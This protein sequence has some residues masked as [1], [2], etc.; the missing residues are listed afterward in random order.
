MR[1]LSES[2]FC[3][4]RRSHK[5]RGR[6]K[7]FQPG[8]NVES[9]TSYIRPIQRV[10]DVVSVPRPRISIFV[11]FYYRRVRRN[12]NPLLNLAGGPAW[13][14]QVDEMWNRDPLT[15]IPAMHG[16]EVEVVF[17]K[18]WGFPTS[19][20]VQYNRFCASLKSLDKFWLTLEVSGYT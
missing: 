5:G 1:V 7:I 19:T 18:D 15:S 10:Y 16:Y 6:Q 3:R 8:K 20:P 11:S 9:W 4:A 12:S 13:D 2:C 17:P 14:M